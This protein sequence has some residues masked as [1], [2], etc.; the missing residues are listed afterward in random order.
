MDKELVLM[1]KSWKGGG[2]YCTAGIDTATG[3]WVRIISEDETI[4]HAVRNT[5]M[6]YEDGTLPQLLDIVRVQCK[7]H[8]PNYYQPENYTLDSSFYWEKVGQA[9]MQDVINL[10]PVEIHQNLF[11]NADKKISP[12]ELSSIGD[13]DKY[14]LAL[15]RPSVVRV[16]VK[17]WP[18]R[19]YPSVTVSFVH[20]S[21][22]Y[23]FLKV[24]DPN[25][26]EKY[27]CQSKIGTHYIE[28]VY[29]VM[30]LADPNP[31]DNDHYKL[32]ATV[33]EE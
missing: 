4:Q 16:T 10:R 33:L 15:I 11:Y 28:D 30:S 27:Q 19:E 3:Q 18:K 2:H 12:H 1:A 21:N 17:Q 23:N 7:D 29:F 20:M 32:I 22:S 14:S 25:F 24:T 5:D 6:E 13:Y 26:L 31:S 9:S 8:K